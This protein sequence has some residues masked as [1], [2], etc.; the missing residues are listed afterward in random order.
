MPSCIEIYWGDGFRGSWRRWSAGVARRKAY[1]TIKLDSR[2]G[3]TA[4]DTAPE[5]VDAGV[6]DL[7]LTA[8]PFQ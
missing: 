8:T 5:D 1:Y 7:L 3:S 6:S 2:S 4:L